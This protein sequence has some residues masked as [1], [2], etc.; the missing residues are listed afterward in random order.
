VTK[1]EKVIEKV[2]KAMPNNQKKI[3]IP[4]TLLIPE[5]TIGTGAPTNIALADG[6]YIF[7]IAIGNDEVAT[8]IIHEDGLRAL[9]LIKP[10]AT[11]I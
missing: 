10:E 6:H 7:V 3:S 9:N 4:R 2:E 11:W 8:L 5:G 1:V